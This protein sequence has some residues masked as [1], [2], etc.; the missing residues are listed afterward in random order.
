MLTATGVS[1]ADL[2]AE[3]RRQVRHEGGQVFPLAQAGRL[4]AIANRCSRE[5]YPLSEGTLGPGCVVT[6][7]WHAR[8]SDLA[9]G[10]ALVGRDPV[11]IYPVAERDGEILVDRRGAPA[12]AQRAR[13]LARMARE[14]ARFERAGFDAREAVAHGFRVRHERLEDGMTHAHAAALRLAGR[15]GTAAE[16]LAAL[17][18]PLG[19]IA[20]DT[21]GADEFPYAEDIA[22]WSGPGFVAAIRAMAEIGIMREGR[23]ADRRPQPR[24]GNASARAPRIRAI[25]AGSSSASNLFASQSAALYD[26]GIPE[27][28]VACHR[29]KLLFAL[30]DECEAAP[31]AAWGDEISA[32]ADRFLHTPMKRRH[33]LR[34][35]AQA[36]DFVA[37][38]G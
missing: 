29:L 5:G 9:R 11:R 17:L 10:A 12:E 15:A 22:E 30:I 20:W 24:I 37:R 13:A 2:E 14:V 3:G 36:L 6:C 1:R 23:F 16:R 18:E 38:E 8:K 4:F 27:P 25:A 31:D 26:H 19:R 7:N 35:A 21:A 28:I 34:I 33:G 32:A